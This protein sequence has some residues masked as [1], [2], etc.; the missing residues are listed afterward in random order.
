MVSHNLHPVLA[1]AREIL[2]NA[3]L[4]VSQW[5]ICKHR[6]CEEGV[7]NLITMGSCYFKFMVFAQF[8][9]KTD[10]VAYSKIDIF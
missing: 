6:R 5:Y 9:Y 4:A 7:C 1:K 10:F 8:M 2:K 3:E